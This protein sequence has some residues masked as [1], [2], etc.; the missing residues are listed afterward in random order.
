MEKSFRT[1]KEYI[2]ELEFCQE[3]IARLDA[4]IDTL[5]AKYGER[6]P[7]GSEKLREDKII[8]RM[9]VYERYVWLSKTVDELCKDPRNVYPFL[10]REEALIVKYRHVYGFP[11]SKVM[12]YSNYSRS[13]CNRINRRALDKINAKCG[14]YDS[15]QKQIE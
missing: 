14:V 4:S 15:S 9:E 8:E 2:G 11:W 10:T 13:S 1:Y 3:R 12:R 6:M 5:T 7:S